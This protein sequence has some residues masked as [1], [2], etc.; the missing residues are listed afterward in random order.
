FDV[1]FY[2]FK[3][4][5]LDQTQEVFLTGTTCE[6]ET[7]SQIDQQ[8]FEPFGPVTMRLIEAYRDFVTEQTAAKS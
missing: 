2:H 5:E 8:Q 4:E 6:I 7:I 1:P 3:P